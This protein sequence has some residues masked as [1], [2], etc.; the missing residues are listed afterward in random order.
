MKKLTI[1]TYGNEILRIPSTKIKDIDNEL[2]EIIEQMQFTMKKENGIGL[3][4]PQIGI[5]KKLFIIKFKDG[6]DIIDKVFINPEL[7]NYYGEEVYYE[8]GCLSIPGIS[9]EIRR[10]NGV[11]IKSIDIN[12]EEQNLRADGLLGRVIQHEYDHL[13][14]RLFTDLLEVDQ[15][16]KV[17]KK[18]KKLTEKNRGKKR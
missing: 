14:G 6:R 9:E 18:L 16:Q 5:N 11:Y 1:L 8:E 3:A 7:I 17:E 13:T 2:L 15:L 10:K 12:G 4:A